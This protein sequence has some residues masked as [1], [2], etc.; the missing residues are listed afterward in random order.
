MS[1][2]HLPKN[3]VNAESR[4]RCPPSITSCQCGV[5]DFAYVEYVETWNKN[6]HVLHCSQRN[7][8]QKQIQVALS[9]QQ[10]TWTKNV[11]CTTQLKALTSSCN[12][13]WPKIEICFCP[14]MQLLVLPL[15]YVWPQLTTWSLKI[16]PFASL[17]KK[18][19]VPLV[20]YS[21]RMKTSKIRLVVVL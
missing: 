16:K 7:P 9:S 6:L 15:L 5:Q 21:L 14:L 1:D 2:V 17:V 18:F 4:V 20:A 10:N 8:F 19:K 12:K 11:K 3:L 13:Y